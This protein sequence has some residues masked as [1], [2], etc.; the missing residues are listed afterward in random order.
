MRAGK[1]FAD[2]DGKKLREAI[3][4]A[5]DGQTFIDTALNGRGNLL[6]GLIAK[7][8]DCY[9][10][11]LVKY[12]PKVDVA[13]ARSI[14]TSAGYTYTGGK[15]LKDGKQVS[16]DLL[17][18]PLL[19]SASDYV[20]NQLTSL[21]F[22]VSMRVLPGAAYG[23]AVL[24]GNFDMMIRRGSSTP[25][26]TLLNFGDYSGQATPVGSNF[27]YVGGGDPALARGFRLASRTP[28]KAACKYYLQG[29]QK[30]LENFY[31]MP[32]AAPIIDVFARPGI[33]WAIGGNGSYPAYYLSKRAGS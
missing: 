2:P 7:G 8:Q 24:G 16:F 31:A 26:P 1:L 25:N 3:Y 13:K 11:S 20:Y 30:I 14:L 23:T 21:G 17:S 19:G 32:L 15:M 27:A 29:E 12:Y 5:V 33:T 4:N 10:P 9:D 6:H 28:G 18:S 22:D